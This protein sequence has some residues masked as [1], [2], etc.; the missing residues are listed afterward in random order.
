MWRCDA[1]AAE[2][3]PDGRQP[4]TSQIP[5]GAGRGGRDAGSQRQW[6]ARLLQA[7]KD[8][9]TA[10]VDS[11]LP[12]G[13]PASVAPWYLRYVVLSG[14]AA[15]ASAAVGVL[16]MQSLLHAVGLGAGAIPMAAALNWVIKDGLG[17][18]GGMA[19]A[20]VINTRFDSNPKRWR[21][22]AA[23][24][25]DAACLIE[26]LTPL[27]PGMFVPLAAVAN[28]GKNV[29]WLSASA[30]RASMHQAMTRK[31]NLGDV[32]AK[33]GSQSIAGSTVGTAVGVGIASMLDAS[34]GSPALLA[35]FA[36]MSAVH[37]V[38]VHA[39]LCAVE[40]PTVDLWVSV[41]VCGCVEGAG[42]EGCEL[43]CT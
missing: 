43:A 29:S 8:A 11:L 39:A 17:Q 35:V 2:V 37:L 40:L 27:V 41:W 38:A 3:S 4:S 23:V 36:G 9:G 34:A 16:S 22:T 6:T 25:L 28:I 24:A 33:S 10:V 1:A 19:F 30:T 12:V 15:T 32:T 14:V 42:F 31:G 20:S 21:L 18:L 7:G 26:V 13:Y 5:G